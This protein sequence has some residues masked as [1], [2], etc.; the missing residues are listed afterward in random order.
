MGNYLLRTQLRIEEYYFL[1]I[2]HKN[3]DDEINKLKNDICEI[4]N[5]NLNEMTEFKFNCFK[6]STARSISHFIDMSPN[7][8]AKFEE[9]RTILC[10]CF[11][12]SFS[13]MKNQIVVADFIEK[14]NSL[15]KKDVVVLISLSTILSKK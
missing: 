15:T 13:K 7:N 3:V 6:M 9:F 1:H 4:M 10:R 12:S 14:T 5:N 11:K 8:S 2:E